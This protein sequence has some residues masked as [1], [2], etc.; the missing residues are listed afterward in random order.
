[1][2]DQFDEDEQA[3]RKFNELR[4]QLARARR[5]L[6]RKGGSDKGISGAPGGRAL[7]QESHG[8]VGRPACLKALNE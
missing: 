5:R 4:L 8:V 6:R 1:M 7:P 3:F 2:V